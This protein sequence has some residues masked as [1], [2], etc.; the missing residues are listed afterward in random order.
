MNHFELFNLPEQFE[1]D[2]AQLSASYQ[3]LQQLTH[4][5]RFATASDQ[6]RLLS[7]QKNAQLNDAYQAL[8]SPLLRAEYLLE[9]RGIDLK[10]ETSTMQDGMFLMQQM[11]WREQLEDIQASADLDALEDMDDEIAG[12]IK[13]HLRQVEDQLDAATDESHQYAADEIRKLKFLYK[14]RSEIANLEEKLQ[15]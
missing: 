5:D 8:K 2:L 6:Q 1:L 14:L 15:D 4:P 9:L 10:H 7:V 3:K 11:E 12:Q 13:L